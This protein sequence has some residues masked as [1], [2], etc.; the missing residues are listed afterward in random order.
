[1]LIVRSGFGLKTSAGNVAPGC[2]RLGAGLTLPKTPTGY[3]LPGLRSCLLATKTRYPAETTA[4]VVIAHGMDDRVVADA[5]DAVHE[6]FP[7]TTIQ[8]LP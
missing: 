1:L 2:T 5:V 6:W 7:T 8:A 3:D 4:T